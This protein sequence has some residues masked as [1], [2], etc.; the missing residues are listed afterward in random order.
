MTDI[1][2]TWLDRGKL[3]GD[4]HEPGTCATCGA[5]V[6]TTREWLRRDAGMPKTH[7]DLDFCCAGCL[8]AWAEAVGLSR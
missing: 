3:V 2:S 5:D 1:E 4:H 7:V 8:E 6:D